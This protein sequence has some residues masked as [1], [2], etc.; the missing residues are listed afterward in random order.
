M[1]HFSVCHRN[2]AIRR[3]S[4]GD[5]IVSGARSNALLL[6]Y[7]RMLLNLSLTLLLSLPFHHNSLDVPPRR[8]PALPIHLPLWPTFFAVV[9][10]HWLLSL[11]WTLGIR[12]RRRFSLAGISYVTLV[13]VLGTFFACLGSE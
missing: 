9:L 2:V 4:S 5:C 7:C 3:V 10:L 13:G 1:E 11:A 6:K 8:H 12:D